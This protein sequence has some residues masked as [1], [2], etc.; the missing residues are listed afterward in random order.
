MSQCFNNSVICL[1]GE[2]QILKENTC[3]HLQKMTRQ[4]LKHINY[5]IIDI[6]KT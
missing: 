1:F 6:T 5:H 3:E 2:K 4:H